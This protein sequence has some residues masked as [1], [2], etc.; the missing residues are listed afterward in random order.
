MADSVIISSID[1][2]LLI[3]LNR[4]E[5]RNAL[6][7]DMVR[8]LQS[9]LDEGAR[10]DAVR[11]MV[12]MSEGEAFCAGADLA[13]LTA[14]GEASTLENAADSLQLMEM[15]Y[16]LRTFPKP[17]IAKVQGP[18]LAGGCGLAIACDIVVA[19][20]NASFG[21]PEVRIG[22]VPAIVM[23]LLTERVGTGI[24]RELL[25]RGNAVDADT[26]QQLGLVNYVV[27]PDDLNSSVERLAFEFAQKVS[28]QA[29]RMTKQLLLETS[30][31]DLAGAMRHA[32]AW[33]AI[34]RSSDDFRTGLGAFL[35][36]QKIH[37]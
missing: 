15:M 12:L 29:V 14:L 24:A 7:A 34:A 10:D 28:P 22:F 33:N 6:D 23:K 35:G 13:Y 31:M 20:E 19:S 18:A 9:A 27:D 26:A 21:F 16:A 36:K 11:V 3:S 37:W 17:V 32:A 8:E 4:P 2:I 1:S 5:K 25:L 30:S